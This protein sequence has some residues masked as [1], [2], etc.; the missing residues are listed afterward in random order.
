MAIDASAAARDVTASSAGRTTESRGSPNPKQ[1]RHVVGAGRAENDG[2]VLERRVTVH[3][4]RRV[5][6]RSTTYEPGTGLSFLCASR[7]VARGALV[8]LVHQ[9]SLLNPASPA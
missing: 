8:I 9:A 2:T 5:M 6:N 1:Q 7:P 4:R 3:L